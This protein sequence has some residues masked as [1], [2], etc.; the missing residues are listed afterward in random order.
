MRETP[1]SALSTAVRQ[2]RLIR[3]VARYAGGVAAAR[4]PIDRFTDPELAPRPA[5]TGPRS[6]RDGKGAGLLKECGDVAVH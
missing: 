6:N 4:P 3:N 2:D 1:R 5:L